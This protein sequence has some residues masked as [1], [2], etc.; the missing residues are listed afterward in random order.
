[1]NTKPQSLD[2]LVSRMRVVGEQLMPYNHPQSDVKLE[3]QLHWVKLKEINIDGYDVVIHFNRA[4][5]ETHFVESVQIYGKKSAF[6]PFTIVVKIARKFLGSHHLNLIEFL[7]D[8]RKIYCWTLMV[9]RRG[10]PMP[11]EF[12]RTLQKHEGFQY[13]YV[14]K[15]Q[16]K[17]H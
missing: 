11:S 15:S 14:S 4:N 2:S 17:T 7:K 3:D 1:M 9:D 5:H 12:E 13:S 16:I 8:N 6:L 10:R